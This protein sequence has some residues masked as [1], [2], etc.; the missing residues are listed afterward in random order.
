MLLFK[1]SCT[2]TIVSTQYIVYV[3]GG[4]KFKIWG[5]SGYAYI[6]ATGNT[7]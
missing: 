7:G 2:L 5:F 6:E 4:T 3:N 1:A